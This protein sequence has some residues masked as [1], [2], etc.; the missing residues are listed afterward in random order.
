MIRYKIDIMLALKGAGY[1][2]YRL[3]K[4]KLLSASTVQKLRYG[5]TTLTIENLNTIC[6][7]LE[8]QPG[9]LLEWYRAE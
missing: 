4:E 2:S 1:N 9:D 5:D 3:Q 6:D 7:M 8:C